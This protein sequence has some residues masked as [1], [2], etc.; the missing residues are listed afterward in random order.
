MRVLMHAAVRVLASLNIDE[1]IDFYSQR[2]GFKEELKTNDY[3][4]VRRDGAEIHFWL[5]G[6]RHIAE[7]TS[8]YV[9][10]ASTDRPYDEFKERNVRLHPTAIRP[11]VS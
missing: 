6:E 11:W 9:R 2:L 7:N 1:T 5:S 3:A 4:I 10:V 8:C